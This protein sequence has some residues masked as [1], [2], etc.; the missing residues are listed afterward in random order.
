MSFKVGDRVQVLDDDVVGVIKTMNN[1]YL[2]IETEDG[3]L[4]PFDESEV[5]LLE[6]GFSVSSAAINQVKNEELHQERPQKVSFKR[7]KVIPAKVYDLH[8]YQLT[9]RTDLS[10]FDM[11]NKQLDFAR[12]QLEKAIKERVPKLV[13]I[14]GVGE[15]VLKMELETILSRYN[16]IQ[17]Y[18][19]DF[20]TYGFGA[21][22]VKIFQH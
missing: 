10:A 5:I 11:L 8:I 21:T 12:Y 22:E 16:N 7:E 17:Y 1:G 20:K 15:G 19:A 3:F 4:M 18:D 14:H 9:D 6:S 13:F 2:D